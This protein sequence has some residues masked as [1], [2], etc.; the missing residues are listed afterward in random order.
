[1]G[2]VQVENI[3]DVPTVLLSYFSRNGAWHTD[4]HVTTTIFRLHAPELRY[5]TNQ[6]K[7]HT[8]TRSPS[9]YLQIKGDKNHAYQIIR[10]YED[11]MRP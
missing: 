1:M 9:I 10:Q 6:P 3:K 4:S 7:M 2:F 5:S 8:H 11:N